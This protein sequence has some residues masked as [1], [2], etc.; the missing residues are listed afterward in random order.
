MFINDR[1]HGI[2]DFLSAV[3]FLAPQGMSLKYFIVPY[4]ANTIAIQNGAS[5]IGLEPEIASNQQDVPGVTD[6]ITYA[7]KDFKSRQSFNDA[8]FNF[9]EIPN[10]FPITRH[11]DS[12]QEPM[13]TS[14][15]IS[16]GAIESPIKGV[17]VIESTRTYKDI[18]LKE[19]IG[20]FP[21]NTVFHFVRS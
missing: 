15:L 21:K 17:K 19:S 18:F 16:G 3:N 14:V 1:D 6:T 12:Q 13:Q 11:T 2:N 4:A 10:E 9:N 7:K 8:N 20:P 5:E